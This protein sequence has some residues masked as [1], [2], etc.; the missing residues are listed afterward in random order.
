MVDPISQTERQ[1]GV[2]TY[3]QPYVE[4]MLG[5]TMQNL[6]NI[7]PTTGQVGGLRQYTPYSY[8]PEDYV[9]GMTPLQEQ[10]QQGIAG[11]TAPGQAQA[12][13]GYLSDLINRA[14]NLQYKIG[15][16]HV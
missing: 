10:A 6:F 11:L 13:T 15:R 7:D 9:A 1:A 2:A 8:R 16:A 4:S 14:G 12:A 3:A 5:A